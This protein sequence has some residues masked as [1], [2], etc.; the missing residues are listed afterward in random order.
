M[1]DAAYTAVRPHL[2]PGFRG[3]VRLHQGGVDAFACTACG[4]L[5]LWAADPGT[6]A[7]IS[8]QWEPVPASSLPPPP[9]S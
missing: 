5:E 6:L 4:Y 3:A 1:G 7:Y 2:P 9:P 8:E